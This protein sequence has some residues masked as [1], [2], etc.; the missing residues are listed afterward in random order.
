MQSQLCP[1]VC[2]DP[3][4]EEAM[5]AVSSQHS[6]SSWFFAHALSNTS[7]AVTFAK[8]RA[9]VQVSM[10]ATGANQLV[11]ACKTWTKATAQVALG[12][13]LH[14]GWRVNT[15]DLLVL[16]RGSVPSSVCGG[17]ATRGGP[18]GH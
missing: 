15:S 17:R 1:P 14:T 18:L 3:P 6:T 2:P 16:Q 7:R 9:R 13:H 5:P 8:S 12:L 4:V 11:K 10:M